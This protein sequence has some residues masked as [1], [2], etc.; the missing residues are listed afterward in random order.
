MRYNGNP[1][2]TSKLLKAEAK[3]KIQETMTNEEMVQVAYI[4]LVLM[5][6]CRLY[7]D[8]IVKTCID[9]KLPY[10]QEI[11][12]LSGLWSVYSR[13]I[14]VSPGATGETLKEVAQTFIAKTDNDLNVLW[15]AVNHELLKSY[16]G[17]PAIS[18]ELY[19]YTYCLIMF[20]DFTL[21]YQE[22]TG[23]K[24]SSIMGV[25]YMAREKEAIK[26]IKRV[27]EKLVKNIPIH[28]G[29]YTETAMQI[30]KN[31]VKAIVIGCAKC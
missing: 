21:A 6:V 18:K 11:K 20:L 2:L 31:K 27:C 9:N 10:R 4:P 5:R 1:S 23:V 14:P 26:K 17:L 3:K 25:P 29:D 8:I 15:Y 13:Y 28:D 7:I 22:E 24:I 12:Q 19:T 30:M 16:P